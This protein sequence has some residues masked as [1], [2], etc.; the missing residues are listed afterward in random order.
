MLVLDYLVLAAI[1]IAIVTL[2]AFTH[3]WA[4]ARGRQDGMQDIK[5][6]LMRRNWF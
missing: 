1:G 2:L 3:Y 5:D 6:E 4:Y